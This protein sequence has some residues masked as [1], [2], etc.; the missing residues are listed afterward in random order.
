MPAEV[1]VPDSEQAPLVQVML[2]PGGKLPDVMLK[3]TGATP[4]TSTAKIALDNDMP[5]TIV[6]SDCCVSVI[7]GNGTSEATER[8]QICRR[9][10]KRRVGGAC[11]A[12]CT[13]AT[14]ERQQLQV[15]TTCLVIV[16]ASAC[17]SRKAEGEC[18]CRH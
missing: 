13:R 9:A 1:G 15:A 11:R 14:H 4:S 6:G 8:P 2:M 7:A 5:V 10:S 12:L 17:S 3:L 16:R 18:G